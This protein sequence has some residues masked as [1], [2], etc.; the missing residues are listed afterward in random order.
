MEHSP[1]TRRSFLQAAGLGALAA[2]LN[3]GCAARGL[4]PRGIPSTRTFA[5]VHVYPG[6]VLRTVVGLRPYRPSGFVVRAER[7]NDK[8]VIHN[9]GHGRLGVTLSWGTANLAV[10]EAARTS[11]HRFA[12]IGCGA[13]GLATARLLQR[14][15][16][17]VTIYAKGLP[18]DTTSNV[19]GAAWGPIDLPR[20][21]TA[22][23]KDQLV[24]AARFSHRW[25]QTMVGAGSGVRWIE[26]YSEST[27]ELQREIQESPFREE[28]VD[29]QELGPQDHPF[30]TPH[31]ARWT[32]MLIEPPIYLNAV[33]RDFQVAGGRIIV[34][35]FPDLPAVLALPEPVI[36]N[37]TGL[38][39][40]DL[41]HD[42]ELVPA[43]GQLTVLLP[44]PEVDYMTD[45][46]GDM[47]PRRDGI[48]LGSTWENG[49]WTLEPNE[50][51]VRRVLNRHSEFFGKMK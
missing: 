4:Q 27:P 34:R 10:E 47:F 16:F 24:R 44:E 5:K 31:V 3:V 39:A 42:D 49:V 20:D 45:I 22:G 18:P 43:K 37:C 14:R 33:M 2:G 50:D 35:H 19:A 36:V 1:T 48:L 32:T 15:G 41:F 51:A 28:Y 23:F 38:G 11:L 46:A 25:F 7:L 26:N 40:R 29:L 30:P 8:V 21:A 17:D 13:V 6:R 12:V 9:Y